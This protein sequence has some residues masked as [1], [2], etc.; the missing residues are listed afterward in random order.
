MLTCNE[1]TIAV[2]RFWTTGELRRT[3]VWSMLC[4]TNRQ[5]S[6]YLTKWVQADEQRAFHPLLSRAM[7]DHE[8][9]ESDGESD[10]RPNNLV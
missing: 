10:D 8:A 6:K 1:L 9:L 3:I 7:L 4:S 2:T 5:E